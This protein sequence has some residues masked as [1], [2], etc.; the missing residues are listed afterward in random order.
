MG[1]RDDET[2]TAC[3]RGSSAYAKLGQATKELIL[4]R[5]NLPF[6]NRNYREVKVP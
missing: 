3:G 2:R 6:Y 4:P 1:Y 5:A